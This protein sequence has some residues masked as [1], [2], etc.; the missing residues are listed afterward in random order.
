MALA[1]EISRQPSIDCATWLLVIIL[2]QGKEKHKRCSLRRK[3]APGNAMLE[4]S[5]VR[6]V[7]LCKLGIYAVWVSFKPMILPLQPLKCWVYK[8][9]SSCLD[10]TLYFSIKLFLNYSISFSPS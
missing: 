5:F 2:M 6:I 10:S 3:R 4:P 8:Y 1:E 9:A 7:L